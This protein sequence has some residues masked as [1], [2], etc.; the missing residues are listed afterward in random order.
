MLGG[1]SAINAHAFLAPAKANIDAW[2]QLGNPGW[3]WATVSRYFRKSFTLTLPS[4]ETA[5]HLALHYVDDE[6]RAAKGPLQL[7][8][9]NDAEN[10]WSKAWLDTWADLGFSMSKDPFSGQGTGAYINAES[11]TPDTKLRSFAGNAYLG[12]ALA[13][14]NVT[15]LTGA[16]VEKIIFDTSDPEDIV[17]TGIEYKRDGKT[18]RVKAQETILSAGSIHSPK[19]LEI[20]GIGGAS[21]LESHAIPLVVDNPNVG[22]NL[23]NHPMISTAFE[24]ADGIE[25]MDGLMRGEPDAL[26]AAGE[27]YAKQ[28]GPFANG[29]TFASAVLPQPQ[30]ESDGGGQSI[31]S[32]LES[33]SLSSP[34]HPSSAVEFTKPHAG[35]VRKVLTTPSESSGVYISLP[36]YGASRLDGSGGP[37]PGGQNWFTL[38]QLLSYPLSRGSTHIRSASISDPTDMD[39]KYFSHPLDVEILAR[40]TQF[41]VKAITNTNS[42]LGKLLKPGGKRNEGAPASFDDLDAVKEYLKSQT[43]GAYHTTGTCAMMPREKGGVVDEKLRV[44]GVRGLRVCD[45]SI[46]P[47][48]MRANPQATVYA[49]AER[50]ADLIKGID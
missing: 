47:I 14:G 3:D 41:A 45:A 4:D 38:I 2:E 39:P 21:L 43:V 22:E 25:T 6:S 13:R 42:P 34:Q 19:L 9:P 49:V 12:P 32:L 50:A 36:G 7:S 33:C 35:F 26:R 1:S 11:I 20:S 5:K 10:A 30:N 15:V 18:E 29:G 28:R 31:E 48:T 40:Q 8:F 17:A 23:Q 37:P 46:V 27:A 16:L 24:A 44:H